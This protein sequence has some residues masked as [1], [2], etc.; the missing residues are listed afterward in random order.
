MPRRS[1]RRG[2]AAHAFVMLAASV[3]LVAGCSSG[4]AAST[5]TAASTAAPTSPSTSSPAS[6][7]AGGSATGSGGPTSAAGSS[8]V[9]GGGLPRTDL[10]QPAVRALEAQLGAPQDY[11]EI[12]ATSH[13]VNVIIA[14]NDGAYAQNWLYLDG[15]LTSKEPQPASGKTFRADALDFD[16]AAVLSKITTDLPGASADLFLI[17]GGPNGVVRYT[18]VV[19]SSKGGQLLV[20]V[21]ADGHV[22]EV[23]PG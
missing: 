19:T 11:F 4:D 8:T 21:G 18:V 16:P 6:T 1:G 14:L 5:G 23:D 12:N 13:L 15:T 17:E 3:A 20:V 22:I 10:I 2:T 7:S 9:P